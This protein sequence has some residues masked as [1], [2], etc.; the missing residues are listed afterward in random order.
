VSKEKPGA[1]G[2]VGVPVVAPAIGNAVFTLT[3]KRIR[4]LPLEDGGIN[5]V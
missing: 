1:M 4:T 2:E 5:F 3:G